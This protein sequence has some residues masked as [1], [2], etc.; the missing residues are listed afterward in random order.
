MLFLR[1]F[2]EEE[3]FYTRTPPAEL[4]GRPEW[5]EASRA[6]MFAEASSHSQRVCCQDWSAAFTRI[7]A[8]MRL[9]GGE[10]EKEK[11]LLAS[12]H[13]YGIAR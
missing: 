10:S 1:L 8:P 3:P 13:V 6:G 11:P 5:D 12:R 7:K 4:H 9:P 2:K